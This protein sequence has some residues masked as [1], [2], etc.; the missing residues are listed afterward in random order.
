M[1]IALDRRILQQVGCRV[2]RVSRR[3]GHKSLRAEKD[4]GSDW[5]VQ[6]E[7]ENELNE[8]VAAA[9]H[10]LQ[11][12]HTPRVG[13]QVYDNDVSL[14]YGLTDTLLTAF[15]AV[16]CQWH[17][18]MHFG[19]PFHSACSQKRSED[20][21]KQET[22]S[23]KR[24]R[25]GSSL[26]IRQQA[27]TWSNL[28]KGLQQLFGP[29]AT[30]RSNVQRTILRL[31]TCSRPET[32]IV[33]L[34]NSGKTVLFVVPSL[35]PQA[36]VTVVIVP[37]IALKHDLIRRCTEWNISFEVYENTWTQPERLHAVPSLLLIDVKIVSSPSCIE[38]LHRLQV[39]G[40]LDRI[41][42]NEAHLL[43][44]AAHYRACLTLLALLRRVHCPF[45][46]LTATLP[47]CAELELRQMLSFTTAETLRASSDR[48]NLQYLV[49][50]VPERGTVHES[51]VE[52]VIRICNIDLKRWR[53]VD[54]Q[55]SARSICFVRSKRVELTLTERLDCFFY[56]GDLE[57][58][59]RQEMITAWSQGRRSPIMIATVAFGAGV[60]YPFIRRIIHVDALL[61]NYAQETG[62]AGRDGL[63][64]VCL[65]LLGVEW[66]VSWDQGFQSDFLVE[67][68]MQMT[69]FLQ[70]GP[71]ECLRQSLTAYLNSG[72]GTACVKNSATEHASLACSSC[73][74]VFSSQETQMTSVHADISVAEPQSIDLVHRSESGSVFDDSDN[75][76]APSLGSSHRISDLDGRRD[77]FS[78]LGITTITAS[79]DNEMSNSNVDDKNHEESFATSSHKLLHSSTLQADTQ[80]SKALNQAHR[81][82]L[83]YND[84]E[85]LTRLNISHNIE[86][87]NCF[88]R[89]VVYW[90]QACILCSFT[91]KSL[92]E[93][94]HSDCLQRL[95]AASLARLRL[96]LRFDKYIGCWRCGLP[97]F[98]CN[99]RG[100]QGCMQPQLLWHSCWTAVWLDRVH[101]PAMVTQLGGPDVSGPDFEQSAARYMGW[102]GKKQPL[103]GRE[104]SNAARLLHS[105][106]NRLNEL[107]MQTESA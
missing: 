105:W 85:K 27:W 68:R 44:T 91:S 18:L 57:L 104:A 53:D 100:Q 32:I 55:S 82:Q 12:A 78:A 96:Q 61:L 47:P 92:I 29:Q 19:T 88:A 58:S 33:M 66:T 71:T 50:R 77:R 22:G 42:L 70:L 94:D 99:R 65:T 103:F 95:H 37:L 72:S 79:S 20:H 64:A 87:Q 98:V 49:Q 24:L 73:L 80:D 56:H 93:T 7:D 59:K 54:M 3:W 16:S 34:I 48:S 75:S 25:L 14:A 90:G 81:N 52:E 84:A 10:H 23:G 6:S 107:C 36:Q 15:R 8:G 102:L 83:I 30:A 101:G 63:P 45:V 62:R 13:R 40:R 60:D 51:L 38:F 17:E 74:L 86:T 9:V 106:L 41:V 31:I 21:L 2:H 46:C 97:E 43:L 35:L 89:S 67:D 11:A 76:S 1:A 69:R 4:S 26:L 28:K 5:D 39:K